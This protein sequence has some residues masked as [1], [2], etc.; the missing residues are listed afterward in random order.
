MEVQ[1]YKTHSWLSLC[2]SFIKKYSFGEE[3]FFAINNLQKEQLFKTKSALIAKLRR[4]VAHC[5]NKL[6]LNVLPMASDRKQYN[7]IE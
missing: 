6:I 7:K 3:R 4:I 2:D 5:V 1:V